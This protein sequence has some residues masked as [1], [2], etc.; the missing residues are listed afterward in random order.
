VEL[1]FEVVI[2]VV[3]FIACAFQAA[4]VGN[5]C[6]TLSFDDARAGLAISIGV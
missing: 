2:G 1:V 6:M 4:Q 5:I 3:T